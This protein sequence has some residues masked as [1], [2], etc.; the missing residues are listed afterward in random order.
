MQKKPARQYSNLASVSSLSE[1]LFAVFWDF[2]LSPPLR[3]WAAHTLGEIAGIRSGV[4]PEFQQASP[5]VGDLRILRTR[6]G[7]PHR[8]LHI[9]LV[10]GGGR[11]FLLYH[12]Q[13]WW[14]E[15]GRQL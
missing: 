9:P 2:W 14:R 15:G 4:R 12:K 1:P 11:A 13:R 7:A 8:V 10:R 5:E 3:T 6:V